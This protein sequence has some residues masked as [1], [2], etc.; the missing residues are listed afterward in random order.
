MRPSWPDRSRIKCT[1]RTCDGSRSIPVVLPSSAPAASCMSNEVSPIGP[2]GTVQLVAVHTHGRTS[3]QSCSLAQSTVVHVDASQGSYEHS[4]DS[5]LEAAFGKQPKSP[6]AGPPQFSTGKIFV[7]SSHHCFQIS[8]DWICS[9]T[10]GATYEPC[11]TVKSKPS[12][13]AGKPL[14]RSGGYPTF[15]VVGGANGAPLPKETVPVI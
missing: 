12:S 1:L 2:T 15:G 9:W 8:V 14:A 11:T 6:V 10:R 5:S 4:P 7:C 3:R 13:R